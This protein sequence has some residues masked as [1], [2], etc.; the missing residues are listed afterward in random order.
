ML[1][2]YDPTIAKRTFPLRLRLTLPSWRG[3][4]IPVYHTVRVNRRMGFSSTS[5]RF[6]ITRRVLLATSFHG[7]SRTTASTK[8]T[9]QSW[10]MRQATSVLSARSRR[11][12]LLITE[13]TTLI[14]TPRTPKSYAAY[15]TSAPWDYSQLVW[16]KEL[17]R[18]VRDR[19]LPLY[20]CSLR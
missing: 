8:N 10:T 15:E 20:T 14:I 16:T 6:L 1:K 7:A 19:D 9:L 12:R 2:T 5:P 3:T 17:N 11:K 13:P 18:F 4:S